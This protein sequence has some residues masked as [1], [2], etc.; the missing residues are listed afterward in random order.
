MEWMDLFAP[1]I[2]DRGIEYYEDGLVSNLTIEEDTIYAEV[3]GSDTYQI[4]IGLIG[5]EILEMN[6]DCPY[7]RKGYNCKHMAAVLFKYEGFLA[8]EDNAKAEVMEPEDL[9]YTSE[10]GKR[11]LE[12]A[13]LVNKIPEE[14]MRELLSKILLKDEH[15]RNQLQ[16]KYDFKMNARQMTKLENEVHNIIRQYCGRGGFVDWKYAFHFISE[17]RTFLDEKI[18]FLLE[19]DCVMQ[20]FKLTNL[21]FVEV[22]NTDMDDSDGGTTL[23][24]EDCYDYWEMILEKSNDEQKDLI[25]EWFENH[26]AGNYVI[27]YMEDYMEEFYEQHLLSKKEIMERM[28]MLDEIVDKHKDKNDCRKIYSARYGFQDV[29]L[30]R[31]DCMHKLGMSQEEILSYREGHRQFYSI[32]ELEIKEALEAN[33]IERAIEILEESKG[34]DIEY[35]D[36]I[37]DY[38]RRLIALY[39]KQNAQDKLKSELIFQLLQCYQV[40]LTY[41][42]ELKTCVHS[43]SEWNALV[44][45]MITKSKN[46][47]FVCDVLFREKRY[48]DLM[49]TIEKDHS[50][51]LLDEYEKQLKKIYP[52]RVIQIYMNYII[53]EMDRVCDRKHYR[54]LV[55]YLK[56]IA[57]CKNGRG[58]A[59]EIAR[60]WRVEYKRRSAL[61]D[62]L[63]KAGF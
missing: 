33:R 30:Q 28:Q 24:A 27:D 40:D 62:E 58:K 29:L 6:C 26:K 23:L 38:S 10:F 34:L 2:L 42:E 46:K 48:E 57:K 25:K 16:L 54:Y 17:L 15:L 22:G 49:K 39:K 3:E 8:E 60:Q 13:S 56:K 51:E 41:Y 37:R 50:V 5:D 44:E 18:P 19:H 63:K 52:E 45:Q 59:D 53:P 12:V 9:K 55:Q 20:A 32:R 1:H 61:M 21:V 31:I 14:D 35:P 4:S 7:A 47:Q 11:E 43:Q 36:K